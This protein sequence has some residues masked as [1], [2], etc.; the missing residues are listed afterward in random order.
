MVIT[1][2]VFLFIFIH[3]F[4]VSPQ[5]SVLKYSNILRCPSPWH[6]S[7]ATRSHTHT[8]AKTR[9]PA[10]AC[11]HTCVHVCVWGSLLPH[12]HLAWRCSAMDGGAG[13]GLLCLCPVV[14]PCHAAARNDTFLIVPAKLPRGFLLPG[15]QNTAPI[16]E[17]SQVC[18]LWTVSPAQSRESVSPA[19]ALSWGEGRAR[20]W[21][22]A[23]LRQGFG[24]PIPRLS[25]GSTLPHSA[26]RRPGELQSVG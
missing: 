20:R 1:S 5:S 12:V 14:Y 10:C 25:T 18:A 2:L 24:A 16:P 6:G 17:G 22:P 7:R 11:L 9:T 26:P 8:C 15:M 3:L 23:Q 13:A 19:A 4:S 21:L